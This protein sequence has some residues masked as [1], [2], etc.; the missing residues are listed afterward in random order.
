VTSA[1]P[2]PGTAGL[3]LIGIGLVLVTRKRIAWGLRQAT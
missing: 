3:T 2:E 1:V